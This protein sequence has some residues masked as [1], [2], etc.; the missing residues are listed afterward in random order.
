MKRA[1]H[2]SGLMARKSIKALG[3]GAALAASLALAPTAFAKDW[4]TVV[5]GMEG[6]YEPWNL[7]DS[8]GK[9]VGFEV[10]LAMDLCKRAG[11]ECKV[12][13]QDW[14]GMIP[15]LKAGKFDVIMDGMSITDE[16]KKKS[17]SPTPAPP[18]PASSPAPKA[19]PLPRPPAVGTLVNLDKDPAA[20]D[21]A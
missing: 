19:P 13:A 2:G 15:G 6:A 8:S 7:T 11:L 3:F 4:K 14:D 21:A 9:I 16:R 12:I 10:D 20:G 1:K 17:F 5:I 18:P